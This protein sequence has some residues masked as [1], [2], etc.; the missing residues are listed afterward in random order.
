MNVLSIIMLILHKIG[1]ICI[2]HFDDLEVQDSYKRFEVNLYINLGFKISAVNELIFH[3][4]NQQ[5][6]KIIRIYEK[7]MDGRCSTCSL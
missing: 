1:H 2:R 7:L 4:A 6:K 5:K 3:I